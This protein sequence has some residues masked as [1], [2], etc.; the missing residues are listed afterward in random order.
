MS[1]IYANLLGCA[2]RQYNEIQPYALQKVSWTISR[3]PPQSKQLK[4]FSH[5]VAQKT[6]LVLITIFIFRTKSLSKRCHK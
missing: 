6:S 1:K 4:P 2:S 5:L 3:V